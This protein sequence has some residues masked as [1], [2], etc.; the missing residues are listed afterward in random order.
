MENKTYIMSQTNERI[1]GG[2]VLLDE[3]NNIL[4]V[5]ENCLPET[6]RKWGIPKGSK[7]DT[8]S[9]QDNAF[10]ELMEETGI[11]LSTEKYHVIDFVRARNCNLWVIKIQKNILW[12]F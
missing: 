8:E 6:M 5:F 11:N 3:N 12:L 10:R 9:N 4:L 1:R 7:L 2:V